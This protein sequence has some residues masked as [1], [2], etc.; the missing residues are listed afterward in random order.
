MLSRVN[1]IEVSGQTGN[2]KE[3]HAYEPRERERKRE[4]G[5]TERIKPRNETEEAVR[6]L[7]RPKK[8]ETGNNGN[9]NCHEKERREEEKRKT[10]E[11]K[12][13]RRQQE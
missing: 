13:K 7:L 6:W 1:L 8:E 3:T 9:D 5:E 12:E 2:E 11:N 4:V 10:K